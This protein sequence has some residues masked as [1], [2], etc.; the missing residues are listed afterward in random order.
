MVILIA[1]QI[2]LFISIKYNYFKPEI[3]NKYNNKSYFNAELIRHP[4]SEEI[5][6]DTTYIENNIDLGVPEKDGILLYGMN[7]GGKSTLSKAV[8]I[9]CYYG[10]KWFICPM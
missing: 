3:L 9:I 7:S 10:T 1:I 8:A 4:I 6:K 2:M 5:N